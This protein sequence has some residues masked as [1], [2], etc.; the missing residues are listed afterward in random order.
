MTSDGV[1]FVTEDVRDRVYDE[2]PEQ[3]QPWTLRPST[4]WEVSIEQNRP[5]HDSVPIVSESE[6]FDT[7]TQIGCVELW[8]EESIGQN[9]FGDSYIQKHL[10]DYEVQP[11]SEDE[12][13]APEIEW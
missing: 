8:L 2:I 7:P 5:N 1:L 12:F 13:V 11:W 4:A 9:Q 6:Q 10:S 3:F